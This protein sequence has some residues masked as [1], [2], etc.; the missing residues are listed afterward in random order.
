MLNNFAITVAYRY[1]KAKKH[2]K[3]VSVISG[4]SLLGV[5]IGV[6]AL[7]IVMSVMNGFHRE[8]T[9]NIIGLNG[10]IVI[11][12]VDKFI[13]NYSEIKDILKNKP[14]IK[15]ITPI[16]LNQALA[17]G[18]NNTTGI[19]VRGINLTDLNSKEE[20]ING[21]KLGS[22]E[23]FDSNKVAAIGTVLAE[24]LG[25]T[26]GDKLKIISANT[27]STAF[28]SMPRSREVEIIAIFSSGMYDYDAMTLLMTLSGAQLF[29]SFNEAINTIEINSA[30]STIADKYANDIQNVVGNNYRSKSWQQSNAP[31]MN[32]LATERVAMFTILSLIIIVAAFNI[33]SSLFMLVKSKTKD[34]AILKTIG[35]SSAQVMSIFIIDGMLVGIIGTVLGIIIGVGF[36]NNIESIRKILEKITGGEI[37]TAAI[38]YLYAL[39][40]EIHLQDVIFVAGMSI[41]FCF[42]ATIYPSYK[43][44]KL[45]PIEA[46]RYE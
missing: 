4:F 14:Y 12:P 37:F 5:T 3:L 26:V 27:I 21:L 28:G 36:A 18:P 34:I 11:K 8:L 38:Y 30:D 33:V 23:H 40:S 10:D 1:F 13:D 31:F 24:T 16:I 44:A 42:L 39:P 45:S 46:M 2:E 20:I 25:V 7:I 15:K 43:A 9:K 22:F 41:I 17:L 32:A 19:L 6:A 35:A 29:F